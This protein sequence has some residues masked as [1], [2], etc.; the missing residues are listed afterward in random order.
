MQKL[1]LSVCSIWGESRV[2]WGQIVTEIS[3][4]NQDEDSRNIGQK[5]ILP[6]TFCGGPRYKSM[7]SLRTRFIHNSDNKPQVDWNFGKFDSR[8]A[9]PWLPRATDESFLSE[10]TKAFQNFERLLLWLFGDLSLLYWISKT[11]FI[12]SPYFIW[13]LCPKT[14][15]LSLELFLSLYFGALSKNPSEAGHPS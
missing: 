15:A 9:A 6:A 1:N 8:A 13:V 3:R 10:N 5:I 7:K 12:A 11:W 4:V 2:V 14:Q